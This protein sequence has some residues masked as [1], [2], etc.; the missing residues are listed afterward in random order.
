MPL[1]FTNK[2][3]EKTNY[4]YLRE[5]IGD[6]A[7]A[8]EFLEAFDGEMKRLLEEKDDEIK[9][10]KSKLMNVPDKDEV[11]YDNK[12]DLGFGMKESLRWSA[13]NIAVSSMMEELENC[14]ERNLTPQQIEVTLR[15]I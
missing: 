3:I 2:K 6:N 5:A 14:F 12:T 13:P 11:F 7:E 9:E 15:S 10:L 4:Q 1:H 8:I